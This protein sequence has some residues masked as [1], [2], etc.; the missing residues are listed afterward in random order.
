MLLITRV[1]WKEIGGKVK[2]TYVFEHV[3]LS[4]S[5]VPEQ[6]CAEET[7]TLAPAAC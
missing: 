2:W 4:C 5:F 6:A 3:D 7:P 1:L